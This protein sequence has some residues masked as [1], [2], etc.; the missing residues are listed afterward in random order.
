M[1][2]GVLLLHANARPHSAAHTTETLH[3]LKGQALD[4]PSCRPDLAPTD[5]HLFGSLKE[6]L[7]GRRFAADDDEVEE[8]V[9]DWLR[10]QPK[11]KVSF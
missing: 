3:E 1:S 10:T 8:D 2:R 4:S 9:R 11:K 5:F 6:A 7:R